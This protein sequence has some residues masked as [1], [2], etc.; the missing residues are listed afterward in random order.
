MESDRM[1]DNNRKHLAFFTITLVL[2]L[3]LQAC[4]PESTPVATEPVAAEPAATPEPVVTTEPDVVKVV[5]LPFT[6]HIPWFI[7]EE[8]G[9]FTAENLAVELVRF[10]DATRAFPS[11]LVGDVDVAGSAPNPGFFNAIASGSNVKMVAD[12]GNL[13]AD[14][15]TYMALLATPDWI[16][17]F[18]ASPVDA[19]RGVNISIDPSN[20]EAYMFE[21]LIAPYGLTLDDVVA[22]DI[23]PPSLVEAVENHSVEII[24]IGEPWITRLV[25]TGLVTVWK[26]Y[27]EIVPGMQ[28]GVVL[29]GPSM[30]ERPEVGVRFMRA[31]L[32]AI[33]QYNEGKTDRNVEIMVAATGLDVDL[34]QRACWPPMREDGVISTQTIDDLQAWGLEKGL[35]DGITPVESYWDPYFIE[36]AIP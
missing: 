17:A 7:A 19:L 8:E 35:F 9:Y 11:L 5:V 34:L 30:L 31:Y 1:S 22:Q 29:Y 6:S 33:R 2:I 20:F 24:S 36:Q 14:A 27:Q 18:E 25:D 15:C 26:P 13:A 16:E 10:D 12:R 28:F 23:A 4:A 3:S 32:N 21:T